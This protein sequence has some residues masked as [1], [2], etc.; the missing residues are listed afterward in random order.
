MT[1]ILGRV[2]VVRGE[3]HQ[4]VTDLNDLIKAV[5]EVLAVHIPGKLGP[6][7]YRPHQVPVVAQREISGLGDA[8][9][10][11]FLYGIPEF[12]QRVHLVST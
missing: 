10:P 9:P 5:D 12:G 6:V 3:M 11:V 1:R 2:Y 8:I 4:V 7:L